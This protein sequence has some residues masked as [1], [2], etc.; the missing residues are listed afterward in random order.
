MR[1]QLK[2]SKGK[3][4]INRMLERAKISI[5]KINGVLHATIAVPHRRKA[6]TETVF[7]QLNEKNA[8]DISDDTWYGFGF[9]GLAYNLCLF[10]NEE[11]EGKLWANIYTT[12]KDGDGLSTDTDNGECYDVEICRSPLVISPALMKKILSNKLGADGTFSVHSRY[13]KT[14]EYKGKLGHASALIVPE[15]SKFKIFY[16]NAPLPVEITCRAIPEGADPETVIRDIT[17][18]AEN[19]DQAIEDLLHSQDMLMSVNGYT[20]L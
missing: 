16:E 5:K 6:D 7:V 9:R 15:E 3:S 8:L 20:P 12:Q 10:P 1:E 11:C 2:A 13:Y 14:I 19:F 4:A 18:V 17:K